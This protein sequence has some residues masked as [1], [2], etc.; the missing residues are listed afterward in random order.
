MKNK[1]KI[2]NKDIK[3]ATR[4][5]L[6]ENLVENWEMK[7][8]YSRAGY[9][10]SPKEKEIEGVFGQYG[11]EIPPAVL[12]YMR[13]N[14]QVIMKRL[15]DVYG[16][17]MIEYV[18]SKVNPDYFYG[19]DAVVAEEEDMKVYDKNDVS[20]VLDDNSFKGDFGYKEADDDI[21]LI[22]V[23]EVRKLV[24]DK[25]GK[26]CANTTKGCVR[27]KGNKWIILNNKKGGVW[28]KGGEYDTKE[29]ANEKLMAIHA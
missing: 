27:K 20:K 13:K 23:K 21:K 3:R 11:E 9:K 14:P 1:V 26:G 2:F 8:T 22:T 18:S 24:E 25:E 12:R 10:S 19:E 6:M 4:R 16:D 5:G 17:Q 7:D 29:A 15:Y 28:K